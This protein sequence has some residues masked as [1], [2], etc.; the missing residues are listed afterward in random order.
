MRSRV[1][2]TIVSKAFLPLARVLA[3]SFREHHP[4][5]PFFV[6][7]ADEVDGYFEPEREPFEILSLDDLPIPRLERFRFQHP[8]QPLSYASTP[9]FLHHLLDLGFSSA[10]F[11]KQESLVTGDQGP[12]F[13]RLEEHSIV[14]TPHLLAPL[15]G[16]GAAEREMNILQS[17]VF[18]IGMIGVT[19]SPQARRFLAWWEDR[20]YA[21]CRID[22]AGGMHYEQRWVDLV[23][24]YF[25]DAH[26]LRDP[27]A[28][29]GHWNLPE[30]EVLIRGNEFEVDGGPG[31]LFRFSGF[32]PEHPNAVTRHSP[33]LNM[34]NVGPAAEVFRDYLHRIHAA[35][36]EESRTWPYAWGAFDDGT[37]IPEIARRIYL[38]LGESVTRF[39][40]PFETGF[41]G[42]FFN[43]LKS[44]DG[45]SGIPPLWEAVYRLRPDVQQAFPDIFGSDR[46]RFLEWA[47]LSGAREHEIPNIF[48]PKGVNG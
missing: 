19:D 29:V 35:G 44:T 47:L 22:V 5:I 18:N 36:Y 26:I 30:R 7:L 37:P 3:V 8:Q 34:E 38:D 20:T 14:I 45:T 25:D 2:G 31:R 41:E 12:A 28:N 15:E 1:A 6:L 40:N 24:S 16:S 43:W 32:E 39:G 17:G 9:F 42:T 23:P 21:H 48:L 10:I 11:F 46:N 4:G 33:R 13:E 27:G